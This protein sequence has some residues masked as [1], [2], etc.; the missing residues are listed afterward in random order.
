MIFKQAPVPGPHWYA[1][2]VR[3]RFEKSTAAILRNKG[4][5]EFLPLYNAHRC[6]KKRMA[7]VQFP[8]F[9]GYVFCRFDASDRRVPIVTTPGVI[10]I[11]GLGRVPVPVDDAEIDAVHKLV[12]SGLASEPWPWFQAGAPVRIQHGSLAGVEGIFLEV[13]KRH[14]LVISVTLLQR[15]VAV[16]IDS[17]WVLP[18]QPAYIH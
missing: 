13:K 15:S 16:D 9:P 4:F 6:W 7:D 10:Q 18:L 8:L 12:A 5:Q 3:P 2:H 1:V 17:A 14:R 11:V